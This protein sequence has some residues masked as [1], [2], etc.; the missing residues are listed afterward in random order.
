MNMHAGRTTVVVLASAVLLLPSCGSDRSRLANAEP[1][2]ITTS[3]RTRAAVPAAHSVQVEDTVHTHVTARGIAYVAEGGYL[4]GTVRGHIEM[5]TNVFQRRATFKIVNRRGSVE[6]DATVINYALS[7]S[8]QGTYVHT[9][10]SADITRGSGM[11]VNASSTHLVISGGFFVEGTNA[12]Y[13]V[14]G[15]L[16]Y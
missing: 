9:T 5:T 1:R 6:G 12:I 14:D 4:S 10:D 8:S 3:H 11:Y 16:A 2:R 7:R 15:T 13:S